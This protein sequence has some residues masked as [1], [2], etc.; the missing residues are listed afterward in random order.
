M[1]F[2]GSPIEVAH[3]GWRKELHSERSNEKA[4]GN[5]PGFFFW[6]GMSVLDAVDGSSTGT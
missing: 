2:L 5:V 6:R 1:L 3:Y 4:L